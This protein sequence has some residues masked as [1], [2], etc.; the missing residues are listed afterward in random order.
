[1]CMS[2]HLPMT[3]SLFSLNIM[4]WATDILNFIFI[5]IDKSLLNT[6]EPTSIINIDRFTPFITVLKIMTTSSTHPLRRI[7]TIASTDKINMYDELM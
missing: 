4:K 3:S 6:I 5:S 2:V 7:L 1:M